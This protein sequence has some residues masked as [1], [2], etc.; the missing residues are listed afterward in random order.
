[1]RIGGKRFKKIRRRISLSV[2]VAL[3]SRVSSI[4]QVCS[5]ASIVVY[6]LHVHIVVVIGRESLLHDVIVETRS[7]LS[8]PQSCGGRAVVYHIAQTSGMHVRVKGI[9]TLNHGLVDDLRVDMAFLA[10]HINLRHHH[11]AVNTSSERVNLRLE[12][13]T[14]FSHSLAHLVTVDDQ[15]SQELIC[16]KTK[17]L[18]TM[19]KKKKRR[20]DFR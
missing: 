15:H 1:M 10:K 8:S 4:R 9:H 11:S 3:S 7:P 20:V 13:I 2:F 5:F 19:K 6:L 17:H 18:H 14:L 16:L 12:R